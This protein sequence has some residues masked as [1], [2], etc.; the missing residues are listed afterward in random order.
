[1]M[2]EQENMISF[3]NIVNLRRFMI[4]SITKLSRTDMQQTISKLADRFLS[5]T[6][7]SGIE[8]SV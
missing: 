5:Y 8:K 3:E 7:G 2:L 4:L 6:A 1:M